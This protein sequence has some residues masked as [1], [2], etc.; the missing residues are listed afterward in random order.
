MRNTLGIIFDLD[1]VLLLSRDC[2]RRAFDEVLAGFGISDFNYDHFAGWRTPEV[3]RA[4]FA[5]HPEVEVTAVEIAE[6]ST[7]KSARAR[8]LLAAEAPIA[9]MCVSVLQ[10]CAQR[11]S[12]ALAS[13]GSRASVQAFLDLTGTASIFQS[14]LSGDDVMKAKP[15]PELF[16]RSIEALQLPASSCV[17][18]EDAPAGVQAARLAGARAIGM[19][20]DHEQE[21]RKAGAELVVGTLSELAAVFSL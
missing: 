17:V 9:P 7:R 14:V 18:I 4:V 13:S 11:F 16:T 20:L 8:Q 12:L 2:H 6:C 3:F 1:G 21:L 19:G 5:A 15:D 10:R